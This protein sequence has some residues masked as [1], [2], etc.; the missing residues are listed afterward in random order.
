[1]IFRLETTRSFELTGSR[2]K[3]LFLARVVPRVQP[4]NQANNPPKMGEVE[5][6]HS[7]LVI[8]GP[9]NV[10]DYDVAILRPLCR[11]TFHIYS[12]LHAHVLV[13]AITNI[14]SAG[15]F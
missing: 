14:L 15:R 6:L 11:P 1:M 2:K 8:C 12:P 13:I 10:Q 9:D 5:Q 7:R 3:G 4:L